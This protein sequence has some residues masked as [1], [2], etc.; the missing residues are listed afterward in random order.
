MIES[1][2]HIHTVN[3]VDDEGKARRCTYERNSFV[4]DIAFLLQHINSLPHSEMDW[5]FQ[6]S[7]RVLFHFVGD[8]KYIFITLPND[9]FP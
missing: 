4:F 7:V 5:I 6:G 9:L 8:G 1:R 2:S 3:I